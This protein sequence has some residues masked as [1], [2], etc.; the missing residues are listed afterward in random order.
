MKRIKPKQRVDQ[1]K[2]EVRLQRGSIGKWIY[3]ALLSCLIIWLFDIFFGRFFYLQANGMVVKDTQTISLSYTAQVKNIDV[4]DGVMVAQGQKL[5]DVVAM[6]VIEQLSTLN[7][8]ISDLNTRI[9]AHRSRI[10]VI[11]SILPIA[12]SRADAMLKLR[13]DQ[14]GAV[15]RGL[16]GTQN[17]SEL[18]QDEFESR[19]NYREMMSERRALLADLEQLQQSR[20]NLLT[21][22][23]QTEEI[24]QGGQI[25]ALQAGLVSNLQIA[26]GSVIRPGETIL[27]I[28]YGEAYV[29]AYIDTD[30]LYTIKE[31]DEV[32]IL[33]GT[34]FIE[35]QVQVIYP[36]SK[37]LPQEFQRSFRPLERSTVARIRF[38]KGESV[39]P[40]MTTVQ[41]YSSG[42]VMRWV[43]RWLN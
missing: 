5:G 24:Y 15:K 17:M 36:L 42:S 38:A 3:L 21:L 30:A 33:F 22:S 27:D 20:Q 39:P 43:K 34:E 28:L 19:V 26:N 11:S 31:N 32:S 12:K 9:G 40:L 1:L 4:R 18:L 29:L 37:A 7:I 23:Q 13:G 25:K 14:E 10:E 41:V 6:E 8:K 2:T 16:T 35:G